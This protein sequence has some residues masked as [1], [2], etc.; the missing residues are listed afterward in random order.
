MSRI[1]SPGQSVRWKDG[2]ADS[3]SGFSCVSDQMR[4]GTG[5]E[6]AEKK[7]NIGQGGTR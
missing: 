6:T 2:D 4:G 5:Q 1:T 3:W 7:Y